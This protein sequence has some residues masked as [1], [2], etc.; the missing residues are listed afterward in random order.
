MRVAFAEVSV[1]QEIETGGYRKVEEREEV[2]VKDE[3]K[4]W[5]HGS[6]PNRGA[7]GQIPDWEGLYL[8]SMRRRV[9]QPISA[10]AP[11]PIP[12]IYHHHPQVNA[13]K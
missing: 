4:V 8:P 13:R 11:C 5:R 6:D 2:G 9:L 3:H 1:G 12:S 10:A 7:S